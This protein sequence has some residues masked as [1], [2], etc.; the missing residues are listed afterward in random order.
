MNLQTAKI[1][2]DCEYLFEESVCPKCGREGHWLQRW[3]APITS[4]KRIVT[5]K[6]E[7]ALRF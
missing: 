2:I 4:L 7:Q 5:A 1:C 3:V 6:A